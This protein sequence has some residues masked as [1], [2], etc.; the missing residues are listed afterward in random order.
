LAVQGDLMIPDDVGRGSG[1]SSTHDI[2][3]ETVQRLRK[4]SAVVT[5]MQFATK[6]RY[7]LTAN[8]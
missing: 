4:N 5:K 6:M 8:L 7:R 3:E 2:E 1:G